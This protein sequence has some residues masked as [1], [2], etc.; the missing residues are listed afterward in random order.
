MD[1]LDN[2]YVENPRKKSLT[3]ISQ[4][5]NRIYL[6]GQFS[7]FFP[8]FLGGPRNKGKYSDKKSTYEQKIHQDKYSYPRGMRADYIFDAYFRL[9]QVK[10]KL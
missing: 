5:D 8:L 2:F 4:E 3:Y 9:G 7:D 6:I 10:Q 1:K